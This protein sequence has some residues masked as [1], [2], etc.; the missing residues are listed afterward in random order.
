[1]E[2]YLSVLGVSLQVSLWRG[3]TEAPTEAPTLEDD[4]PAQAL[5]S[6]VD[7]VPEPSSIVIYDD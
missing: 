6:A 7:I 3:H 1:M 2:L 4:G 5:V